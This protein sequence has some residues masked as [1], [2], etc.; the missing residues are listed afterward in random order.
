MQTGKTRGRTALQQR[1]LSSGRQEKRVAAQHCS[2]ALSPR[3]DRKNAWPHSTAATRSLLGET[4]KTRGRTALQQR[5]LSSGRQEKRVAA[6][7]CSNALSPRGD[8]KNAWPHSTAATRS[9]LGETGKTR[10]RTAL[11]Q[12]ALSSGRQG[13]RVAAQ[14]CSNALS[15]RGDRKNAWPHSTAAT[16]SLLGET[17]KTRGRTALQQRALSSGRQE[18][19]VAAQHCSNALSPRGDRKNA[20]PHSTAATRSLLGE[21]GKTRGR[22]ALQQ[23]ALSSGRQEKRVAAQHCSNALSPRGD[24]KNAWPHST[25]ATRSLLGETGKTR[26]RTALQQR[27]L[28]SGR[29]EK[30]VA[31]QHCSNA[32]SPRGDR[33]NAWPHSTAATRSL[34]GE[35]GKTRGRTALQ[36]RALSSG[37][38][39]KRVAAQHCSNALSPRGDRKNAWPHST[40]ATRSLLGETGKTRGR[41]ALQQ[42]ALSSGRQEKRVAAQ[43]C[44]NALSPRGDRKNAWPHSTAA[45]RSLLGETGKTRGRT[46]L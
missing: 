20:W 24:R 3:G 37:R 40:A 7:H 30:R 33:E 44:S 35:T 18:K 29:Q 22:T 32:L 8:R 13:K 12:R 15:P 25:V 21:T 27:A 43:H 10:G 9:L 36:Q 38:Q 4:G 14:H 39:E 1:A 45:T 28:S 34:L 17:G 11:Q 23:R 2:N 16:R 26:G 5:A 31:A 42:R 41:T 19:R 46:A 6:Q